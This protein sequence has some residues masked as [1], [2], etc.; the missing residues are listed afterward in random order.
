MTYEQAQ[1]IFRQGLDPDTINLMART[2]YG[3]GAPDAQGRPQANPQQLKNFVQNVKMWA[4]GAD[5]SRS[6]H[7]PVN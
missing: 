3:I 5:W 7:D 6:A 2:E 4:S 1:A